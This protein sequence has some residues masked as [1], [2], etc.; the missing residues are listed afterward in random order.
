M[1]FINVHHSRHHSLYLDIYQQSLNDES[2]CHAHCICAE[3]M[4]NIQPVMKIDKQ[5][6]H[7]VSMRNAIMYYVT[8]VLM[9][10]CSE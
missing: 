6:M 1:D 8:T 2:I 3:C 4:A 9:S 7:D 5:I 10:A